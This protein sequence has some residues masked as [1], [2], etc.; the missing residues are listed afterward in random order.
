[1]ISYIIGGLLCFI[2]LGWF[3]RTMVDLIKLPTQYNQMKEE[4]GIGLARRLCVSRL[5]NLFIVA[6]LA[7]AGTKIIFSLN[8]EWIIFILI[9]ITGFILIFSINSIVGRT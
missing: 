8:L 9:A 5:S 3:F 7:L 2:A 6:L 4:A 1:M